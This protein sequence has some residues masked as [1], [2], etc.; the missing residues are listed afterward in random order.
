MSAKMTNCWRTNPMRRT[1]AFLLLVMFLGCAPTQAP[2]VSASA[3]APARL[4]FERGLADVLGR[5]HS[6]YAV[7]SGGPAAGNHFNA[8][9]C[10][11]AEGVTCTGR[12]ALP[13]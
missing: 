11:H 4:S 1:V 12:G 5:F 8:R 13:P 7:F 9:G 10:I 3:Q 6:R 2:R